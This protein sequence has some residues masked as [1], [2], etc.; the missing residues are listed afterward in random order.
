M[1]TVEP[2][3]SLSVLPSTGSISRVINRWQE[4]P[5]CASASFAEPG[6]GRAQSP[7]EM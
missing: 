4:A 5:M 7:V 2:S 3:F 1:S 6:S